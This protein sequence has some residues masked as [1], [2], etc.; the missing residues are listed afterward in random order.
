MI[1]K[2]KFKTIMH[3]FS[4]LYKSLSERCGHPVI[5]EITPTNPYTL[6]PTNYPFGTSLLNNQH[7][8]WYFHTKSDSA[9]ELIFEKFHFQDSNDYL[10]VFDGKTTSGDALK[11]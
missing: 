4:K 7:C 11:K 2:C 5:I 9:L 6:N 8:I 1:L 3:Y 10:V